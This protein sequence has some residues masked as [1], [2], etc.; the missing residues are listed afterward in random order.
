M[1]RMEAQEAPPRI[2]VLPAGL[3]VQVPPLPIVPEMRAVDIQLNA[4]VP[5][6]AEVCYPPAPAAPAAVPSPIVHV[7]QQHDNVFLPEVD[8]A[9]PSPSSLSN[10]S[11]EGENM[12]ISN[13]I[14]AEF[15]SDLSGNDASAEDEAGPE[16]VSSDDE[17][18]PPLPRR[19][20]RANRGVP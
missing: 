15:Q 9:P 6:V 18:E 13:D 2:L 1:T 11:L 17:E 7:D 3:N 14:E 19:S 5:P 12:E 4:V 10:A 8:S 16:V 20:T